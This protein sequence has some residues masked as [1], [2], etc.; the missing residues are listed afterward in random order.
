[1]LKENN[2]YVK[3]CKDC[4]LTFRTDRPREKLCSSCRA[5]HK[6]EKILEERAKWKRPKNNIYNMTGTPAL[7]INEIVRVIS[8]Y[9]QEHNT[10]YTYGRF[11]FAMQE[12]KIKL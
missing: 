7:S 6:R 2:L 3:K 10:D 5:K 9:N 8:I 4:G 11:V 1:M 12:G